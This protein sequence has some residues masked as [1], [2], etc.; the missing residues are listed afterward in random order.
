M[1][2]RGEKLFGVVYNRCR[3]QEQQQTNCYLDDTQHGPRNEKVWES[4][5]WNICICYEYALESRCCYTV[6]VVGKH[7]HEAGHISCAAGIRTTA[8]VIM[9]WGLRRS[10]RTAGLWEICKIFKALSTE[11]THNSCCAR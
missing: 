10:E 2:E 7:H 1:E 4:G 11:W 8:G 9:H 5:L 3:K 6:T